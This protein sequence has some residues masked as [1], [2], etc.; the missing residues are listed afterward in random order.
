MQHCELHRYH[1]FSTACI[2]EEK[3]TVPV[4]KPQKERNKQCQYYRGAAVLQ[5]FPMQ[6]ALYTKIFRTAGIGVV[7]LRGQKSSSRAAL[8]QDK[9]F[10][11]A[12]RGCKQHCSWRQQ[13]LMAGKTT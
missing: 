8:V 2:H 4:K 7:C 1:P 6:M 11:E 10:I 9:L 3:R 12:P 5:Y 13:Q